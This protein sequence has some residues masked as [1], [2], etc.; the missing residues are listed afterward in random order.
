MSSLRYHCKVSDSLKLYG[1]PWCGDCVRSKALLD[2][3]GVRYEYID[4]DQNVDGKEKAIAI[5]GRQSIPVIVFPDGSFVVEP[6]DLDLTDK[7]VEANL[8]PP[9]E[10]LE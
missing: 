9:T 6:S 10:T 3:L 7:L 1:A 2:R 4:V 5:S 8:L